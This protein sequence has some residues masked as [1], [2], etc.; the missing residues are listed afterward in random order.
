MDV[1]KVREFINRLP[2]WVLITYAAAQCFLFG[3][4]IG[5]LIKYFFRV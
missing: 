4:L 5:M 2:L 3:I 1:N